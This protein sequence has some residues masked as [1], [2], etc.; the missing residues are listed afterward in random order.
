MLFKE[1]GFH[2]PGQ[3]YIFFFSILCYSFALHMT[4]MNDEYGFSIEQR[5]DY[6][7]NFNYANA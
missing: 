3:I 7:N 6:D 2:D 4:P 5:K 1:V